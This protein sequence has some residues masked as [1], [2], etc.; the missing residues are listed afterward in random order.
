VTASGGK[1]ENA[2]LS[3]RSGGVLLLATDTL[4]GLHCRADDP[5]AIERVGQIKGRPEGKTLLVLAGD[6]AQVRQLAA[7]LTPAQVAA[8]ERC[9][10]GPFSLILPARAQLPTA[11]TGDGGTVAIRIPAVP[12]LRNLILA[13][14]VPL[15]S[16]SAN[17][18][19]EPPCTGL[20][21]AKRILGTAVDGIW[22]VDPPRSGPVVPSALVNLTA[23]PCVVLRLGPLPFVTD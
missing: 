10:P 6:L 1:T 19:G 18:S 2:V 3:L 15:V 8:C 9:W 7:P 17:L 11:V 5:V 23:E 16:T 4:P 14:G 20:N 12:E 22:G 21:E 13:V